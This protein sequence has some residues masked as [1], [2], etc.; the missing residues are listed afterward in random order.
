MYLRHGFPGERLHVLPRPLVRE[1]LDRAPTS[2]LLVTDAG[3]FPHAARHGRIRPRGSQ[4]AIV[5]MCSDGAGWCDL[6]RQ[7]QD[8]YPGQFLIIPPRAP[9]S[10][11]AD[12]VRPWSI[13][14]LHVTGSDLPALLGAI[15]LTANSPVARL[16]D[17]PR[18]FSLVES[19]CDDLAADETSA[20]LTAAA[21]GAW[22]L[23]A[24]LASERSRR[25][26]DHEPIQRV[27]VYLRENLDAATSVAELADMS[28]FS[29]SHFSARFRS[30]TGYT[31]TE[32]IK[33]L[34][35]AR[36][37]TLLITTDEPIAEVAIA[38]GYSDPF[39]FSRQFTAVHHVSPRGFRARVNEERLPSDHPR[40]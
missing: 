33:R 4:Q 7:R 16:I 26:G 18:A 12:A 25:S 3:Y 6:D 20:S 5:I 8:I 38:V 13:W 23:L 35:M 14:W 15:G 24:R 37:R 22:N 30:V 29:V 11:Y 21:G 40:D 34:R 36:A 2:N 27:Q 10:Y 9:H 32:Y 19:V 17:P 39:Y 31:T 28:G 1:A